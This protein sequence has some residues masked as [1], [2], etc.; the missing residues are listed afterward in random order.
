MLAIPIAHGR[1]LYC[2][3]EAIALR[4]RPRGHEAAI[5][6][7]PDA[8]WAR[9]TLSKTVANIE[10]PAAAMLIPSTFDGNRRPVPSLVCK[11]A[12]DELTLQVMRP[13]Y[14][15]MCT[16]YILPVEP[17]EELPASSGHPQGSPRQSRV[18]YSMP[19]DD[20]CSYKGKNT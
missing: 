6:L 9:L 19:T 11:V 8:T 20:S 5:A 12:F 13:L 2:G 18:K 3:G 1:N 17:C 16:F 10:S 14:R 15:H 7:A 4:R